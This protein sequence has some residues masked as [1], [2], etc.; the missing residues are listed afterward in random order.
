[1]NESNQSTINQSTIN[2]HPSII[3]HPY[4]SIT[5]RA[6]LWHANSANA[7]DTGLSQA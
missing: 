5:G 1:M 3:I 4:P 7:A 6:A 2:H